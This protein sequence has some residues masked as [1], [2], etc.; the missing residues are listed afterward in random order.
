MKNFDE[1][2]NC[3]REIRLRVALVA[4]M[5]G[6]GAFGASQRDIGGSIV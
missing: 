2:P 6:G 3:T 5:L 4:P 1:L